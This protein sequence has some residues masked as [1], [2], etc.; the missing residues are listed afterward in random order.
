MA[1]NLDQFRSR[2]AD[3]GARPSLFEME[4]RWPQTVTSGV[5]AAKASRFMVKMAELPQST[6]G[7]IEV[8]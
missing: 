1:F 8:G 4:L 2:L 5:D 3:G 6:V 7:H